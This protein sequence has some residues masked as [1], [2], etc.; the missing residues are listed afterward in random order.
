MF[1]T[2]AQVER[3]KKAWLRGRLC[4]LDAT[5]GSA[6]RG[7]GALLDVVVAAISGA[8]YSR[9]RW[10]TQKRTHAARG[11]A[12]IALKPL[13]LLVPVEGL[14]PPPHGLQNRCSTS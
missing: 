4:P 7:A 12:A 2:H 10:R 11:S 9:K 6:G 1:W 13:K 8:A 5:P 3:R 14:E